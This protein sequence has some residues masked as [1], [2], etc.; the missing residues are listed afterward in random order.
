MQHDL[1]KERLAKLYGVEVRTV[2]NWMYRSRRIS[3]LKV[4]RLVRFNSDKVHRELEAAGY[5]RAAL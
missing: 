2:T 1:T 3:F 5:I 4:G